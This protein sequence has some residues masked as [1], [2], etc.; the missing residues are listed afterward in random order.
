M[1]FHLWRHGGCACTLA[2]GTAMLS[3]QST[4]G[5]EVGMFF[6]FKLLY[7]FFEPVRLLALFGTG[8]FLLGH[9]SGSS[10]NVSI[11]YI[12]SPRHVG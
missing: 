4:L 6:H 10:S 9:T 5:K 7:F 2:L 3:A 11:T 12:T 8:W 1:V